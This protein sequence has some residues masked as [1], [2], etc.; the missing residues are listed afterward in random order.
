MLINYSQLATEIN[1]DPQSLG[2]T[3]LKTAGNDAGI[4]SV[5][6]TATATNVFKPTVTAADVQSALDPTEFASLSSTQLNQLSV[7]L[8]GGVINSGVASVRQ[9][10]I[11]IFTPSGSFPSTRAALAALAQRS[12][13]RAEVL[14]GVGTVVAANDVAKALGRV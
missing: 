8:A 9:I 3:P 6:N 2:Y 4:A 10:V 12:G 11:S 5:L 7:M 13:T 14:F 1:T